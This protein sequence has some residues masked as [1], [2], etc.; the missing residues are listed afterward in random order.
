VEDVKQHKP[1][2]DVTAMKFKVGDIV[3]LNSPVYK[4][5][6]CKAE[7]TKVTGTRHRFHPLDDTTFP[8]GNFRNSRQHYGIGGDTWELYVKPILFDEDLFTL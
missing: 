4:V 6:N 8:H 1:E 3:I 2:V 7:I 5:V